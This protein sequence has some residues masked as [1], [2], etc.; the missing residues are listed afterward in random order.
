MSLEKTMKDFAWVQVGW[1]TVLFPSFQS[2]G[3]VMGRMSVGMY[4]FLRGVRPEGSGYSLHHFQS[5][6]LDWSEQKIDRYLF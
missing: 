4:E 5:K 1:R 6:C 2:M 3:A